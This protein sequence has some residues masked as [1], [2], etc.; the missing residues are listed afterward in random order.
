MFINESLDLFLPLPIKDWAFLGSQAEI[1]TAEA[2]TA[3][4]SRITSSIA[5]MIAVVSLFGAVWKCKNISFSPVGKF[6]EAMKLISIGQG[7]KLSTN[8]LVVSLVINRQFSCDFHLSFI[9]QS[10]KNIL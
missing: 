5:D 8:R 9:Y 3:E 4:S 1:D 6:V 2:D 10:R 7:E